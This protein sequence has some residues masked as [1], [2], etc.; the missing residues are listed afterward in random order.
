MGG[1]RSTDKHQPDVVLREDSNA[2]QVE[3]YTLLSMVRDLWPQIFSHTTRYH[4]NL[5]AAAC[6]QFRDTLRQHQPNFSSIG[7]GFYRNSGTCHSCGVF[8][9]WLE[10]SGSYEFFFYDT[11]RDL[12][13]LHHHGSWNVEA[14]RLRLTV[15]EAVCVPG[16]RPIT[17]WGTHAYTDHN[18]ITADV[19]ELPVLT[20]TLECSIKVFSGYMCQ[21]EDALVRCTAEQVPAILR[22][23]QSGFTEE[24]ASWVGFDVVKAN[25]LRMTLR[26]LGGD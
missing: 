22:E 3:R 25:Y 14:Q 8:L 16:G 18:Q 13:L 7:P 23:H 17:T 12:N 10:A 21:Q 20:D 15:T 19:V 2:D 11:I 1:C 6:R 24:H 5:C 26:I 4:A 9:L